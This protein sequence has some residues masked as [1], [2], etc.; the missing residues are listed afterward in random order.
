MPVLA[1]DVRAEQKTAAAVTIGADVLEA[2]CDTRGAS[3]KS[4]AQV[5]DRRWR[6]SL[7]LVRAT[8]HL[9]GRTVAGPDDLSVLEHVLWREPSERSAVSRMV[10]TVIN[11]NAAKAVECLDAA[12]EARGKLPA[13]GSVPRGAFLGACGECNQELIEIQKRIATLGTGRKINAARDEVTRIHKEV[14]SLAA[15]AMGML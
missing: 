11:P 6:K 5:S 1:I 13:E 14:S 2:L 15:K 8:A 4:G 7:A 10:Q 12:R 9:D 3:R